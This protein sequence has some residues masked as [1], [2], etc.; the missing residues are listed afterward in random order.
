[1]STPQI[2]EQRIS[3]LNLA[4]KLALEDSNMKNWEEN[5]KFII[6]ASNE[7]NTLYRLVSEMRRAG[8]W[9]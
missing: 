4:E 8:L 1:M 7:K 2:I 6:K 3:L 5:F 9:N